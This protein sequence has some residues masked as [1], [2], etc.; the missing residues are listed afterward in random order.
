MID[1]K[2]PL[3]IPSVLDSGIEDWFNDLDWPYPWLD[4]LNVEQDIMNVFNNLIYQNRNSYLGDLLL[5]NY[6]TYLDLITLIHTLKIIYEAKKNGYNLK[7]ADDSKYFKSLV[8]NE[9][10]DNLI[11]SIPNLQPK[12]WKDIIRKMKFILK[13]NN[14]STLFFSRKKCYVLH[15]SYNVFALSYLQRAKKCKIFPLDIRSFYK[16]SI[17]ENRECTISERKEI[18]NLAITLIDEISEIVEHKYFIVIPKNILDY[19][20]ERLISNFSKT[21]L[22]YKILLDKLKPHAPINLFLGANKNVYTRMFTLA[23]RK[24]GGTVNSFMHGNP[25]IHE[26][27]W[28]SWLELPFADYFYAFNENAAKAFYDT[29]LRFSAPNGNRC[30]FKS[31]NVNHFQKY[32]NNSTS[33]NIKNIMLVPSPYTQENHAL[34]QYFPNLIRLH[35]EYMIIDKLVKHG[36]KV[37]YQKHPGD[38]FKN[39]KMDFFSKAEVLYSTFEESMHRADAFIFYHTRTSTFGPALC[40]TKPVIWLDGGWEPI[41]PKVRKLLEKRCCIIKLALNDKHLYDIDISL[42]NDAL[43]SDKKYNKEFVETYLM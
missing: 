5:V 38:Y 3:D 41:N 22:I 33:P 7:Y 6:Y 23:I 14:I 25:L 39:K 35:F 30:E 11:I 20:K 43:T 13:N 18:R 1:R 15:Q 28:I 19:T 17:I 27:D 9:I 2:F 34:P 29:S 31:A 8:N 10:P 40:T 21:N 24:N 16:E 42:I 32:I 37:L 4:F 36:Y 12:S 26:L